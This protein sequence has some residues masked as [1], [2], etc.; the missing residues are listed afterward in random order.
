MRPS[1]ERVRL[2]MID[3]DERDAAPERDRLGGDDADDEPADQAW[4]CCRRDAIDL[5]ER[6]PRLVE[7]L[8]DRGIEQLDMGARR[9]LRHHPAIDLVQV[10]LRA[11]HVRQDLAAPV[12]LEPNQGG[13]RLVAAR[14]DAENGQRGALAARHRAFY[15]VWR[16]QLK[17]E[18]KGAINAARRP[19]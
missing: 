8:K 3:R 18:A 6:K 13:S 10:E 5:I 11:H 2:E 12:G 19:L 15:R 7:R 4:P 9:D 17:G 16:A 1:S 14:L